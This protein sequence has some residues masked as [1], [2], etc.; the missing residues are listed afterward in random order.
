MSPM[1]RDERTTPPLPGLQHLAKLVVLIEEHLGVEPEDV[2]MG[3]TLEH[4]L[5]CDSLDRFELAQAVESRFGLPSEITDAEV[6]KLV[7]VADLA[8][9]I[10]A[11]LAERE[12]ATWAR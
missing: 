10:E 7:T 6:A 9:L 5:H 2:R 11:K 1:Q 8:A 3:A 4:D 12:A